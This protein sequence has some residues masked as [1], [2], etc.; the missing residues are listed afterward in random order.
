MISLYTREAN[1]STSE[2]TA[3][4]ATPVAT[5]IVAEHLSSDSDLLSDRPGRSDNDSFDQNTLRSAPFN[6]CSGKCKALITHC[7]AEFVLYFCVLPRLRIRTFL[8][9][10]LQIFDFHNPS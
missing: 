5:R 7:L 6:P 2:R 1:Y 10:M 8:A 4:E 9:A 3:A